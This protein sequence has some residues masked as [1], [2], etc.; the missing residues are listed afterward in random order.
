MIRSMSRVGMAALMVTVAGCGEPPKP[1]PVDTA[2]T[3]VAPAPSAKPSGTNRGANTAP[4][5][6]MTGVRPVD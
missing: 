1:P 4:Y 5:R 2:A 3:S 6:P